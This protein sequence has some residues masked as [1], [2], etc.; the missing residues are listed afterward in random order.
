MTS[1][2]YNKNLTVIGCGQRVRETILPALH[3][4][5]KVN[6]KNIITTEERI[7]FYYFNNK[8]YSLKTNKL[9]QVNFKNVEYIYLG[10][11]DSQIYK[12]I[13][14][15]LKLSDPSKIHLIVDTPPIDLKNIFKISIFNKFKTCSVMEESPFTPEFCEI[16]KLEKI[17]PNRKIEKI[18]YFHSGYMYHSFSQIKKLFQINHFNFIYKK[19]TS[20]FTEEIN[21]FSGLKNI[22][23]IYNPRDYSVGRYL[24]TYS[25]GL[26]SNY[27]LKIKNKKFNKS[28]YLEHIYDKD[29][30]YGFKLINN[31]KIYECRTDFEY[32]F[33]SNKHI[34]S[35][36]H[37][38]LK[39]IGVRNYFIRLFENKNY[40]YEK[41]YS[42]IDSTY[43]YICTKLVNKIGFFVDLNLPLTK[44]SIII[45]VLE[46]IYNL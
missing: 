31:N 25:D 14:N 26:M 23:A 1:E 34:H 44:K 30:Y 11:P 35:Q 12:T 15:L 6:I 8:K 3:T 9:S 10:I 39:E 19:K 33:K 32:T 36:I 45:S 38:I 28:I 2:K 27:N 40:E 24:I 22:S 46:F 17:V 7:I 18:M 21:L 42:I 13:S 20:R 37:L 43:D 4:I 16:K 41:P 29:L 5:K